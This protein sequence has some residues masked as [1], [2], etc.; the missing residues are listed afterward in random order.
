MA[1]SYGQFCP[2]AMASEIVTER[3]TPLVLRCLL[4]GSTRFNEIRRGVP[5]MSPSLLSGRLKR[6][7]AAG[8]VERVAGPDQ[9]SEY[10]LTPAG[11]ELRGVIEG[12][13][14]WGQRW[15]RADLR[16]EHLDAGLLMWD[17]RGRVA[18]DRLPPQRVVVHFHLSG[19]SD[20][21][22]R[23]WLVLERPTVELCL[24]DPGHEVDV[25]VEAEVETMVRYWMGHTP[26]HELVREGRLVVSGPRRLV[27]AVPGWFQRSLFADVSPVGPRTAGAAARREGEAGPHRAGDAPRPAGGPSARR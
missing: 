25:L 4:T 11:E 16:P 27:R 20:G 6:L 19:S 14:H 23:F 24:F 12:L 13:G 18:V 15:A 2:V 5:R 26:F 1:G 7:E 17:L 22:S 21:R 9:G 10:R 8:I 3:W